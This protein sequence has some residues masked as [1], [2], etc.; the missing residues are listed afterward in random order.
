MAALVGELAVLAV[1]GAYLAVAYRPTAT[2][3]WGPGAGPAAGGGLPDVLR[4]V[5]RWVALVTVFPTA[6]LLV[7]VVVAGAWRGARRPGGPARPIVAAVGI[8]AVV[9]VGALSGYLLPW[10]Q[11]AL[12]AVTIGSGV[13]GYRP[14]FDGSV[15]FV[16]IRGVEVDPGAVRQAFLLHAVAIPVSLG[17]LAALGWA[18]RPGGAAQPSPAAPPVEAPHPA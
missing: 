1:T 8:A 7:A 3:A 17:A 5:H 10:D 12:H 16:L 2:Q 15:A 14:L 18:R 13:A 9:V 4:A 11:L 6:P